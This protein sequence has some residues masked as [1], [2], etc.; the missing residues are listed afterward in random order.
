VEKTPTNVY[1]FH[2]LASN[3]SDISLI[4][5]IRDGRDVVTSLMKRGFN[6]FGSGSRWLY[7][8]LLGLQARNNNN[9]LEVRYEELVRNPNEVLEV[10]F[11]H[12]GVS[13]DPKIVNKWDKESP[14]IYIENWKNR[15]EPR[16]WT[17]TPTDPISTSSVMR[18]K[19]EL[20]NDDICQLYRIHLTDYSINKLKSKIVS[21][22]DLLEFLGYDS[23]SGSLERKVDLRQRL[24]ELKCETSDYLRRVKRYWDR[25]YF[26]FPKRYTRIS[27]K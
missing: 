9:Y 18:Y 8:T 5:I 4:H 24:K 2:S 15:K 6:L 7:D 27:Y 14:G 10:I 3:Y 25:I 26:K 1:S 20:T 11:R 16:T 17:Y 22:K 19:R 23:S 21:F 13:Y 12:L